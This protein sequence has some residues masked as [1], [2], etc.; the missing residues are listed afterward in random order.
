MEVKTIEVGNE[1]T[2]TLADFLE[3][4]LSRLLLALLVKST[5]PTERAP[6]VALRHFPRFIGEI[7]PKGEGKIKRS[8]YLIHKLSTITQRLDFVNVCA[9]VSPS[10]VLL[11]IVKVQYPSPPKP[12]AA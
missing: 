6:F 3:K 11:A 9:A 10:P 2:K 12:S 7:Y 1:K 8:N 5:L 4:D